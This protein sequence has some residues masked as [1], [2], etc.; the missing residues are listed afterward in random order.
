MLQSFYHWVTRKNSVVTELE[1]KNWELLISGTKGNVKLFFFF[2][3]MLNLRWKL[4]IPVE[5]LGGQLGKQA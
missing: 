2:K 1:K 3:E 4:Y 5:T